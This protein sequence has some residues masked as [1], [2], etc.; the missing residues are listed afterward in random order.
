MLLMDS[1]SLD[2]LTASSIFAVDG[3][4]YMAA[5][6]ID[7]LPDY[8]IGTLVHAICMGIYCMPAVIVPENHS[9]DNPKL[10]SC[11]G[12]SS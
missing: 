11:G 12:T 5:I 4:L 7:G 8:V 1:L 3:P 6:C 9:T 2:H 10:V